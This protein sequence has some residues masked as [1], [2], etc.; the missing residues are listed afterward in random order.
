MSK[1]TIWNWLAAAIMAAAMAVALP[2]AQAAKAPNVCTKPPAMTPLDGKNAKK[3]LEWL[4][5]QDKSKTPPVALGF[6]V[7]P[8]G[9]TQIICKLNV[10][11]LNC[12]ESLAEIKCPTVVVVQTPDGDTPV[13]VNCTGPGADGYCDCEFASR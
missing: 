11:G 9:R 2:A 5:S 12:F 8:E 3:I 7:P 4:R 13:P 6:K 10:E 1:L